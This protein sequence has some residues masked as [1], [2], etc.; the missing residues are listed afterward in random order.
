MISIANPAISA[1]LGRTVTA[2]ANAIS[3]SSWST[4]VP[5][6]ARSDASELRWIRKVGLFRVAQHVRS[7]GS[8]NVK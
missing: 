1:H 4:M 5:A 8:T 6:L 2:V 3:L 7:T